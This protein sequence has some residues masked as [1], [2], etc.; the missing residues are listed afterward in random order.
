MPVGRSGTQLLAGFVAIEHAISGARGGR[1]VAAGVDGVQVR[2]FEGGVE[3]GGGVEHG[4]GKAVP[5]G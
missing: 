1:G 2:G 3:G 5:A 4:F